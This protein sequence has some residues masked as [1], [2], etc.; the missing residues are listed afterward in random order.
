[1][2]AIIIIAPVQIDYSDT[3]LPCLLDELNASRREWVEFEPKGQSGVSTGFT[4]PGLLPGV[5]FAR[6]N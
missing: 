6:I 1:M 2:V 5:R 3:A 4:I